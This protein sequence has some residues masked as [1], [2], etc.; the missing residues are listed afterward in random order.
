[1]AIIGTASVNELTAAIV[2]NDIAMLCRA[3]GLGKKGAQRIV[4]ELKD[5]ISNDDI[6]AVIS[7]DIN[8]ETV[9]GDSRSEALEALMVLGYSRSEAVKALSDVYSQGD[10]TSALIKKALKKISEK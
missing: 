4:L 7:G 2:A 3:P 9:M 6:S 10:E 8:E 1:M 5:K